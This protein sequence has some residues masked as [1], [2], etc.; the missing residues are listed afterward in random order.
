MSCQ[1]WW[2]C[3]FWKMEGNFFVCWSKLFNSSKNCYDAQ[4]I[5]SK[6]LGSIFSNCVSEK[7]MN[8]L[9]LSTFRFLHTSGTYFLMSISVSLLKKGLQNPNL[10]NYAG[11]CFITSSLYLL[12]GLGLQPNLINLMN[13]FPLQTFIL[14]PFFNILALKNNLCLRNFQG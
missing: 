1:G 13:A 10:G 11:L 9:H 8:K 4:L 6:Y 3:T 14:Q 2:K 12:Q 7:S 5:F